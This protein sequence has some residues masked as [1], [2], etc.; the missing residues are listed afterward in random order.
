MDSDVTSRLHLRRYTCMCNEP[1][2]NH[3]AVRAPIHSGLFDFKTA[4]GSKI[5]G[6]VRMCLATVMLRCLSNTASN[7]SSVLA[8][9]EKTRLD[10]TILERYDRSLEMLETKI[11]IV[12]RFFNGISG[13]FNFRSF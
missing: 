12:R 8:S 6:Y 9:K 7:T 11:L 1:P 3:P 10:L 2:T 4:T 13:E 5:A